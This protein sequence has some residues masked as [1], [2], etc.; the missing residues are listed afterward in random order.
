[1]PT[2]VR[3]H[4]LTP[5]LEQSTVGSSNTVQTQ[6]I[7]L[8][9]V[10]RQPQAPPQ[11]PRHLPGPL[12]LL[13]QRIRPPTLLP[14]LLPTPHTWTMPISTSRNRAHSGKP[15]SHHSG[16]ISANRLNRWSNHWQWVLMVIILFV[17][18]MIL[19][20]GGRIWWR[21]RQRRREGWDEP[22]PEMAAWAPNRHSVHDFGS[23]GGT[24]AAGAAAGTP[25]AAHQGR[26]K[27]KA[28][29]TTTT[30]QEPASQPQPPQSSKGGK[31]KKVLGRG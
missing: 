18:F 24:M 13:L 28:R 22:R 26:G 9:A 14:Q 27:G 12:P 3:A 25:A 8:A 31:L 7:L 5:T 21:R 10:G 29:A 11:L 20:I 6:R 23:H 19:G 16:I 1:M 4:V 17:A 2:Y 15:D 30:Q